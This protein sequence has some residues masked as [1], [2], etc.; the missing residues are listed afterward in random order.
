MA[1][2]FT[3]SSFPFLP[4]PSCH[5]PYWR[6]HAPSRVR[7]RLVTANNLGPTEIRPLHHPWPQ[8]DEGRRTVPLSR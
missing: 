8:K 7:Q 2:L 1:N 6:F 3:P 4:A 5:R